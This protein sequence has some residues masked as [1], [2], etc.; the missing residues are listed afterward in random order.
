[1]TGRVLNSLLMIGLLK[2][3]AS[4]DIRFIFDDTSATVAATAQRS[5]IPAMSPAPVADVNSRSARSG[6]AVSSGEHAHG[7]HHS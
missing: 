1:M 4:R 6:A 5:Q 2:E 3:M 7:T